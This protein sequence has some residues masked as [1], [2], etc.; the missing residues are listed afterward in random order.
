MKS[1]LPVLGLF[2]LLILGL[3]GPARAYDLDPVTHGDVWEHSSRHQKPLMYHPT[4][5]YW[6]KG[7]VVYYD[8]VPTE[9]RSRFSPIFGQKGLQISV[10][11]YFAAGPRGPRLIVRGKTQW[12]ETRT[13]R[14]VRTEAV[15][16]SGK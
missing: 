10:A 3:S 5:R 4:Q 13:T 1:L 11:D 2:A 9:A 14:T 8:F 6:G 12:I 7:Y 16:D 15:A